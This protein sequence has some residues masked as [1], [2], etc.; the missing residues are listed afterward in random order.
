MLFLIYNP[1]C[2]YLPEDQE[3]GLEA[4]RR[5]SRVPQARVRLGLGPHEEPAPSNRCPVCRK[6]FV[7]IRNPCIPTNI[8]I[9][10]RLDAQASS[11]KLDG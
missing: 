6:D 4:R 3:A 7:G 11:T 1:V 8:R 2:P 5:H 10:A 9:S